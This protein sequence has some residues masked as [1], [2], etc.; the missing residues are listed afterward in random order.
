[1]FSTVFHCFI[2]FDRQ[3]D[4][5]RIAFMAVIIIYYKIVMYYQEIT[6]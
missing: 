4:S 6:V 3:T 2:K 1:M 5:T